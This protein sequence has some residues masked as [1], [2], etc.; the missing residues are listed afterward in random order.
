MVAKSSYEKTSHWLGRIS[1]D[2]TT[3]MKLAEAA[4]KRRRDEI[5]VLKKDNSNQESWH[6]ASITY[7]RSTGATRLV[8]KTNNDSRPINYT[9][10]IANAAAAMVKKEPASG[11]DEDEKKQPT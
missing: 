9:R 1:L 7:M 8:F 11:K 2:T 6:S 3:S 10:D 4:Y 5:P